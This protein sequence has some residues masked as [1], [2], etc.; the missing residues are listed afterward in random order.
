[1]ER[2]VTSRRQGSR[3]EYNRAHILSVAR[4]ELS[5][6]ADVSM[7]DIAR[8]AGVVRRTLYGHFP[9]RDALLDALTEEASAALETVLDGIRPAADPPGTALARFMLTI[10]PLGDRYRM[11]LALA[12]R[13]LGDERFADLLRPGRQ[14]M[15][16]IIAQ[17]QCDDV[18]S[19]LLPAE[20]LGPAL[21]A[22]CLSLLESVN[23]GVWR[24]PTGAAAATAVLV[25]AG[26]P[27]DRAAAVVS[28]LSTPGPALPPDSAG[29]R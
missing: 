16:E 26:M 2:A 15:V 1:M 18:F 27:S 9:G 22:V 14:H 8:A 12:R 4:R 21:E 11:L 7:D 6:N 19:D 20:A 17:G 5:I 13:H 28:G 25:A 3:L 24:D 10:W 23:T 29:L